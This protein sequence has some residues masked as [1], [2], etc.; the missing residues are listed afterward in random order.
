MFDVNENCAMVDFL[1]RSYLMINIFHG[2][3]VIA[4]QVE[5]RRRTLSLLDLTLSFLND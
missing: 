3:S 1:C 4:T 5:D 2:H